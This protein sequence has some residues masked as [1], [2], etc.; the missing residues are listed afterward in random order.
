MT[1]RLLLRLREAAG[2]GAAL[3]LQ[4]ILMRY[5]V[6]V[7]ASLAFGIDVNTMEQSKDALQDHLDTV[8]PTLMRRV[9]APFP[10]WRYVSLLADRAFDRHLAACHAAVASFVRTARERMAGNPGLAA[11]PTNLLEAMLAA[12]DAEGGGLTEAEVAGNVFTMLLAGEDTTAN[13]LAWTLHLLHTHP[14]AWR[15]V[16]AEADAALGADALPR[17]MQAVAGLAVAEDCANESMRLRPVAP[18][19]YLENNVATELGGVALPAGTFV[20]CAMRS[21][22]VDPLVAPD[23]AASRPSRWR[24]TGAAD[25]A[26]TAATMPFGGGPR[27]CPGRFLAMLEMKMVLATIARNF[28]LA[29]VGTVD[30][31]PPRERMAFAMSPVG[32]RLRLAPRRDA[33]AG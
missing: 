29:E 6:D 27:I 15:A 25:R 12:R 31:T 1:E 8:F 9:N 20:I 13:T 32:L 3:D 5:S 33:P 24:G 4:T 16:V 30:G 17:S 23:A 2:T 21:G 7:T 10:L 28:E 14:D 19:S 11:Q 26:L 18:T 22:A